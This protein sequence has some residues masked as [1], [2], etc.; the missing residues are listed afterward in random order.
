MLQSLTD[1]TEY[2]RVLQ[3]ITEHYRVLQSIT[4]YYRVLKSITR[5]N[6]VLQSITKYYKDKDKY[7]ESTWTN[8]WACSICDPTRLMI[9][10]L[11]DGDYLLSSQ[12]DARDDGFSI[13]W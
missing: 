4:E 5:Y 10:F 8:F 7:S 3:S 1:I 12:H 2:Y 13:R 9:K 6:K 11:F